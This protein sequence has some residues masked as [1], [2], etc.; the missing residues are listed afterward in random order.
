MT[1][2]LAWPSGDAAHVPTHR[3][4]DG[5]AAGAG[6]DNPNA[7]NNIPHKNTL[8]RLFTLELA[9]ASGKNVT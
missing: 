7:Q 5:A 9:A 4:P 2:A 8:I 6:Q 3:S 1:V